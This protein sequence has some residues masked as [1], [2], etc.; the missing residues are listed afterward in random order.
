MTRRCEADLLGSGHAVVRVHTRLMA[1][2][3][4]S[5][6]ERGKSDPIDAEA[7]ARVAPREPDRPKACLDGPSRHIKLLDQRGPV[8]QRTAIGNKLRRFLHELDPEPTVAS[9]GLRRLRI[10]GHL[11]HLAQ[12]LMQHHETLTAVLPNW[13]RTAAVSHLWSCS[14]RGAHPRV[15]AWPQ[16]VPEPR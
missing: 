13:S 16:I 9:R 5:A 1:G 15:R 11:G 7:V 14:R 10:L 4:R 2:A 8:A 6:R 3:R 12:A